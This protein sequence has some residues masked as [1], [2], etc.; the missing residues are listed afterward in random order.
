MFPE[1]ARPE[2]PE[3]CGTV[4]CADDEGQAVKWL[5]VPPKVG[6]AIFWYNLDLMGEGDRKTLHAGMPVVEGT[7]VGLNIWTRERRYRQENY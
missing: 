3:W 6:S 4:K 2:A 1:V 5:E 7:K